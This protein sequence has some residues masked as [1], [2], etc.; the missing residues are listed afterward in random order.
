VQE[1]ISEQGLQAGARAHLVINHFHSFFTGDTSA[2]NFQIGL[3]RAGQALAAGLHL[4]RRIIRTL[5]TSTVKGANR[6]TLIACIGLGCG[7]ESGAHHSHRKFAWACS[8]GYEIKF[9]VW[10]RASK[11]YV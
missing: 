10:M 11:S 3:D 2:Q 7:A 6:S 9:E 1:L 8:E 4:T 5:S